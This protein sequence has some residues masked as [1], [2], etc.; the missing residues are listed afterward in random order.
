[1]CA[2]NFLLS[3]RARFELVK[4]VYEALL[5]ARTYWSCAHPGLD[6]EYG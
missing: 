1:M 2:Q 3:L 6:M 5:L 4:A